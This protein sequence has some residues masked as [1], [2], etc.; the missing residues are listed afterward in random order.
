MEEIFVPIKGYEGLYEVSNL[1]RIKSFKNGS[2][3]L[4]PVITKKGYF[5]IVLCLNGVPKRFLIH[6]LVAQAFIPNPDNLPF[7][8]HKD[9]VK[10]NNVVT[11]LEWCTAKYNSNYGT[12]K[13]RQS[14]KLRGVLNTKTSKPVEAYNDDG[15]IIYTF[16]SLMEAHRHGFDFRLVSAVCRG[17]H[18]THKGLHWRFASA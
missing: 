4:K 10:T 15:K 14:E 9:E 16:P 18:I 7:V 12:S 6:R 8:N 3:I 5:T 11:N 13:E 2:Q 17:K 1:G